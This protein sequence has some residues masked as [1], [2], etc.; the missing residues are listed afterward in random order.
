MGIIQDLTELL[1]EGT[2]LNQVLP[3]LH[4]KSLELTLSVSIIIIIVFLM[5]YLVEKKGWNY[6]ALNATEKIRRGV[7]N[8]APIQGESSSQTPKTIE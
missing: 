4:V 2:V 8:N 7:N 6:Y 3:S 5:F 1:R